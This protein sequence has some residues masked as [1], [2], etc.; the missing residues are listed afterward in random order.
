MFALRTLADADAIIAALASARSAVLIGAGFIGLEA[1]GALRTRG[2]EVHVVARDEVPLQRVFGREFGG[3]LTELH[4]QHGV[5]FHLRR[6]ASSYDGRILT[7]DDGSVVAADLVIVGVGVVPR[8]GLAERAGLAVDRGIV[9]N[10]YLQSSDPNIYAA[11]DVARYA[12]RGESVRI[13]HWVHAQRQGQAAAANLLGMAQAY[14]EVPFFWTRNYDH[15][16]R[17]VGHAS[18]WDELR[19]DGSPAAF[20][21]TARY[22][23]AGK[24]LAAASIGR[25]LENLQLEAELRASMHGP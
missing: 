1:A 17:Y 18:S 8:T 6:N 13:E 22:F 21:C 7:L 5:V 25:D 11:G 9:V 10:E 16:V 24:L 20:D 23:R 3:A 19:I 12:L 14:A 4:R 2:L 15:S